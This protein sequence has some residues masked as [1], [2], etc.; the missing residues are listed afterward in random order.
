MRRFSDLMG[1]LAHEPARSTEEA[2]GT[3]GPQRPRAVGMPW[4]AIPAAGGHP[5]I[6][7]SRVL[8]ARVFD[9]RGRAAGEVVDLA[10]DKSSGR[11]RFAIVS[12]GAFLGLRTRFH[13]I[14]WGLLRWDTKRDGYVTPLS[15]EEL[16]AAPSLSA[17]DL[18]AFGAGDRAWRER[19]AAYY[20][21]LLQLGAL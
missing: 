15:V 18:E 9:T 11:V 13:P 1:W 7:V 17:D 21:P 19:L 8:R 6:A 20:N 10:V 2:A 14:P 12:F 4:R 3:A 5:M 16:D